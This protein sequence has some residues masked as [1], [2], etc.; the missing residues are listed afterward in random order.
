MTRQEPGEGD[1]RGGQARRIVETLAE[2]LH[3]ADDTRLL[4]A[5]LLDGDTGRAA[6]A[7]WAAGCTALADF[8]GTPGLRLRA[9]APLVLAAVTRNDLVVHPEIVTLLRTRRLLEARR[10][11]QYRVILEDA[12][13]ALSA[14]GVPHVLLKG[15]ALADCVYPEPRLRHSHDIDLLVDD[16]MLDQAAPGLTAA[17]F[18]RAER[19][20]QS[21]SRAW[22]HPSNLPLRLH[23]TSCRIPYY[24]LPVAGLHDASELREVAGVRIRVLAPAHAVVQ[25]CT[26]AFAKG[27]G[28]G[29]LWWAIDLW[30]LARRADAAVWAQVADCATHQHVALPL[31]VTLTYL[32]RQLDGGVPEATIADLIAKA[33]PTIRSDAAAMVPLLACAP[34]RPGELWRL[35]VTWP[36][37][38]GLLGAMLV[39]SPRYV[40]W[41]YSADEL[42]GAGLASLYLR[43]CLRYSGTVHASGPGSGV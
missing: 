43:R 1:V 36:A 41:A 5:C 30:H 17:G 4:R 14:S 22:L 42:G 23:A 25:V 40:R 12:L 11:A 34:R 3:P 24:R 19:L 8:A 20:A 18:V 9:L 38:A 2:L 26:Q 31:A 15:A 13:Q 39:P 6:W 7:E 29:A 32:R 28:P 35:P 33:A 37:K 10:D 27:R 16:R 21:G